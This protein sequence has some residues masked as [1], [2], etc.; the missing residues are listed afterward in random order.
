MINCTKVNDP[1][2]MTQ[3]PRED[4]ERQ[5]WVTSVCCQSKVASRLVS[6]HLIKSSC[7]VGVL[8]GS[9]TSG[10][11]ATHDSIVEAWQY[12]GNEGGSLVASNT[13]EWYVQC[14]DNAYTLGQVLELPMLRCLKLLPCDANTIFS[15]SKHVSLCLFFE[16]Y[17]GV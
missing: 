7:V 17:R 5:A 3:G 10:I 8:R 9:S 4:W 1:K 6:H 13:Y 2:S 14:H 16:G 15:H 12:W 11:G